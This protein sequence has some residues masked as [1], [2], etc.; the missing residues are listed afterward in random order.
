LFS[1]LLVLEVVGT[2]VAFVVVVVV[3]RGLDWRTVDGKKKT[4]GKPRDS[5]SLDYGGFILSLLVLFW[6]FVFG[7]WNTQG[8]F[9]MCGI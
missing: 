4:L 7:L 6:V 8:D 5:G 9:S 2:V 1:G 3:V